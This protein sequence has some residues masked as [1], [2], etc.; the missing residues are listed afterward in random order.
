MQHR[1][2]REGYALA[3]TLGVTSTV[4]SYPNEAANLLC[5]LQSYW[6]PSSSYITAN[7]GGGRSGLDANTIL[8]SIHTFD[9]SAGCD[10]ATFQPCS[11]RAL[12]NLHAYV[13]SFRSI[14]SINSGVPSNEAVAT[15]RYPEDVYMNGNVSPPFQRNKSTVTILCHSLGISLHSLSQSNSTMLITRGRR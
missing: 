11:D 8:A 13:N 7:T 5:F 6:N 9:I 15:G 4:S 1:A 12:A 3:G 2:L 10:A 14:Y